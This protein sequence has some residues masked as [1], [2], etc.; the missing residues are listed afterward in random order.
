MYLV[1][2]LL[3]CCL[4]FV[5]FKQM[6]AYEMRISDWSSDVCSSYL[7]SS[8]SLG[9]SSGISV[10]R[11]VTLMKCRQLRFSEIELPAQ[12]PQPIDRVKLSPLVKDPP[13]PKVCA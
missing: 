2:A 1:V 8:S 12:V 10:T 4:Y 6:T 7:N 9:L 13:L 3:Q 11:C 5:F